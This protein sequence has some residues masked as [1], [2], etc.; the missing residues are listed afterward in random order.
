MFELEAVELAPAL[1]DALAGTLNEVPGGVGLGAGGF[2]YPK[3][4]SSW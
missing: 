2:G 1:E 3:E 4:L